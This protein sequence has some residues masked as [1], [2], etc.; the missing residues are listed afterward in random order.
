[1]FEFNLKSKE[2][3][4]IHFIGIGGISMSGLAE[5]LLSKKYKVSGTDSKNSA[6]IRRLKKLGAKIY[7]NHDM[8]NICGADLIVYTDAISNDNIELQAARNSNIQTIDRASFLG[9]LMKNY[10]Y[11]MAVSGTHGKTTTTS[12]LASITNHGNLEP[13]VLLGGQLDDIGGNVKIDSDDYILTEACEY[14]ANILKYFPTMAIILNI[15]EDHLDYF[16]NINHIVDT[17]VEYGKNLESDSYLIVNVDDPYIGKVINNTKANVITFGILN[18]SDYKAENIKFSKEGYPSFDLKI[19]GKGKFPLTLKVMGK[20]NIYNAIAS[21]AA[22]DTYGVPIDEILKYMNLYNGV[23][24]RLEHKGSFNGI[25]VLDDYAHHP[26]EIKATL[27]AVNNKKGGEIYCVFQPHTFTRTKAL[28]DSFADS[29]KLADNIIITDIYAAR[30]KDTGEIHSRDLAEK[31]KSKGT[32]SIYISTFD[33]VKKYLL[34]NAKKD[35]LVITMG[36]GNVYLI[37]E[38]LLDIDIEVLKRAVV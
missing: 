31:I 3:K 1:M 13:T 4:H 26:T 19:K 7:L 21:I 36:A 34:V 6:I 5:I 28:L 30:E 23:H 17:F 15:D 24:R 22:A 27:E 14:K 25:D 18:K 35:D 29:F 12:M 37:G 20:H 33:E 16:K 9:A 32:N 8:K 11:S 2:H 38:S 10:T